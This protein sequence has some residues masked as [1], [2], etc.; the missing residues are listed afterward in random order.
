MCESFHTLEPRQT[1]GGK[2]YASPNEKT[3]FAFQRN[4]LHGTPSYR[5]HSQA[6]AGLDD[7]VTCNES[8]RGQ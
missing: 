2:A 1:L 6:K 8:C 5:L 4:G 7:E 3:R